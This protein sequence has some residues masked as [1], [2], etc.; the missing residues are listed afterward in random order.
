MSLPLSVDLIVST[1]EVFRGAKPNER[2]DNEGSDNFQGDHGIH[3]SLGAVTISPE[4][5]RQ[6]VMLRGLRTPAWRSARL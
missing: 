6:R 1:F 3:L 5:F 2:G 4:N